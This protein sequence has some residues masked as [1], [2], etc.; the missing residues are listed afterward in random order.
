MIAA[1]GKNKIKQKIKKSGW[2]M[3]VCGKNQ[4]YQLISTAREMN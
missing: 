1:G 2:V 3:L 4:D